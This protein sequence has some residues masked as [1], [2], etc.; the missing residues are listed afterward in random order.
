MQALIAMVN[1]RLVLFFT[2][3][4]AVAL[5]ACSEKKKES[6]YILKEVVDVKGTCFEDHVH[7]PDMYVGQ[8]VRWQDKRTGEIDTYGSVTNAGDIVQRT[9]DEAK[10]PHRYHPPFLI[11]LDKITTDTSQEKWAVHGVS[12]RADNSQGYNSTCYLEVT[13]RGTKLPGAK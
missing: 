4:I 2:L 7:Q 3:S 8:I 6:N 10:N 1:K 12:E 9:L 5:A 11:S 13:K